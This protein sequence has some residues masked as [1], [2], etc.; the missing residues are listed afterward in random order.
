MTETRIPAS[1]E[2]LRA[3][4]IEYIASVLDLPPEDFPTEA[5][6][7]SYGLDSVEAT[8]MA[9]VMEEQFGVPIDPVLLFENPSIDDFVAA[10]A[11]PAPVT[12]A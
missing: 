5:T 11:L 6:F 12:A 8:V 10:H 7:D 9:G 1:Q 3:W 2:E 4:M